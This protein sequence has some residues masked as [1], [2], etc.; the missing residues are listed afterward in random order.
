MTDLIV[1]TGPTAVGKTAAAVALAEKIN[2]EI[3]SADSMQVYKY[4]D[5]GTAKPSADELALAAHHMLGVVTPDEEFSAARYQRMA[6]ACIDDII[7]R[8]KTPVLA[9]GSGFYINAVLKDIAYDTTVIDD[10]YRDWLYRQAEANGAGYLHGWLKHADPVSYE[11]IHPNNVKR[12]ARALEFY[13]ET[14]RRISAVN[15]TQKNSPLYYGAQIYILNMDRRLLYERIGAR[16]ERMFAGGLVDEVRSLTRRGYAANLPPMRG[17][18][19]KE[20]MMYLNG[21][22]DLPETIENVKQATR[23]YA[24]R[25]LTWFRHQMDGTWMDVSEI[26]DFD[27]LIGGMMKYQ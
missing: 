22:V 27:A 15:E 18:G 20:V 14:G 7:K 25:Q 23:N 26:N 13:K 24:K 12:V 8:G 5:I 19:Y 4:M 16:T 6:R 3:V 1:I 21:A 17:L 11:T 9:G 10:T 2:G